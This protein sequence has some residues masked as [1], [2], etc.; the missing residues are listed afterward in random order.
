VSDLSLHP[1]MTAA[2]IAAWCAEHK[3]FVTINYIIDRE[4]FLAPLITA[5]R[6]YELDEVPAF[7]RM[8]AD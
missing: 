2:Q 7:V 5:R 4:G 6:E 1:G 8:Q 3:M